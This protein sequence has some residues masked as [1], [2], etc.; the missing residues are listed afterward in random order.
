[1]NDPYQH[2]E[3]YKAQQQFTEHYLEGHTPWDSGISPP[4]LMDVMVGPHM[5]PRGNALDIGCGTGTNSLEMAKHGW[6]VL[7]VDF[8]EPAI[9]LANR[10]AERE[11]DTIIRHN[12]NVRFSCTDITRLE[13]PSEPYTLIFDLGCLNAIPYAVRSAYVQ[14]VADYAAPGALFLLYAHLPQQ[15]R[16]K[17]LGC[18]PEEIDALFASSFTLERREMGQSPQGGASMW[19]WLRR[20]I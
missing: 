2:P 13:A 11:Q 14:I 8:A 7:G 9:V 5:L 17:P 4:E 12:G 6:S 18:T 3:S 10:K 16:R 20:T 15:D 19:N 1:M